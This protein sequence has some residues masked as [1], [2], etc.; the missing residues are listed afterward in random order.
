[1]SE[2]GLDS[3]RSDSCV[4]ERQVGSK[5]GEANEYQPRSRGNDEGMLGL[6][7]DE[8]I[9][10]PAAAMSPV[11]WRSLST[12]RLATNS[13]MKQ[14]CKGR[15]QGSGVQAAH[16]FSGRHARSLAERRWGEPSAQSAQAS[17]SN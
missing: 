8:T 16:G 12:G 1:M 2:R 3:E 9:D 5:G 4:K 6:A 13:K 10:C 15:H 17:K 11:G 7:N 14:A